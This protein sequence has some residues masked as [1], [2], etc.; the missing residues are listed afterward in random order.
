MGTNK[1]ASKSVLRDGRV[2]KSG[3]CA[4]LQE[5]EA[6]S[7]RK[8]GNG[9]AA[10]IEGGVRTVPPGRGSQ[11]TPEIMR[12]VRKMCGEEVGRHLRSG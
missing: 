3:L 12:A 6:L 8:T 1:A 9:E 5:S 10:E 4:G 11:E 7:G 2:P